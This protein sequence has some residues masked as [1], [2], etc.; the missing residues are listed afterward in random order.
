MKSSPF[1]VV[2]ICGS[3]RFYDQMLQVAEE[4]TGAG[5]IVL[6]PFV[7]HNGGVKLPGDARGEMLDRMHLAKI[8]LSEEIIV[9]TSY[10]GYVGE[11]TAREIE[12]ARSTGK[13]VT[14]R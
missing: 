8:D 14:Y 7:Y 4:L 6:M 10:T 1:P 3:M 2:T 11:S 5:T 12:Y 13:T 9:C